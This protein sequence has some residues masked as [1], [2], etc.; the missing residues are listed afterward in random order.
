MSTQ[1]CIDMSISFVRHLLTH[2]CQMAASQ[3]ACMYGLMQLTK[4][5]GMHL[6]REG[7]HAA[8]DVQGCS[9]QQ[10]LS[11]MVAQLGKSP[12][13][14]GQRWRIKVLHRSHHKHQQSMYAHSG[15]HRHR[16]GQHCSNRKHTNKEHTLRQ[17]QQLRALLH[18]ALFPMT[19]ATDRLQASKQCC[20]V[21]AITKI[22]A[23]LMLTCKLLQTS[24]AAASRAGVPGWVSC[25]ANAHSTLERL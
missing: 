18:R 23:L 15:V 9:C 22:Q 17:Q 19:F 12:Q 24:R 16:R 11:W 14:V 2:L 4:V 5:Q 10:G 25:V 7:L 1:N 21:A 6:W 13:A 3:V 8:A 20:Y